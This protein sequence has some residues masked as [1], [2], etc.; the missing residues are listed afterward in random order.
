MDHEEAVQTGAVERY[1][2]GEMK[3]EEKELFE[4]HYFECENCALDVRAVTVFAANARALGREEAGKQ[5]EAPNRGWRAW[6]QP[7]WAPAF[8]M[9]LLGVVGYQ[10]LVSIPRLNR[11]VA[12]A[13]APRQVQVATLTGQARGAPAPVEHSGSEPLLLVFDLPPGVAYEKYTVEILNAS[14][15]R[16]AEV[17][18]TAPAAGASLHILV[19]DQKLESGKYTVVV[20]GQGNSGDSAK[21]EV[22]RYSFELRRK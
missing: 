14:G 16:V 20:H 13:A 15:S 7:A 19:P 4:E 11:E 5:T 2:L 1:V 21:V 10:A 9:L 8:A 18:V 17:P 12:S 3:P 6:F 22:D